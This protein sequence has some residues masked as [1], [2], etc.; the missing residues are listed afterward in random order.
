MRKTIKDH[1]FLAGTETC[2]SKRD[3][4]CGLRRTRRD[5][6]RF[7]LSTNQA[8]DSDLLV[9]KL[10]LLKVLTRRI[11]FA[12]EPAAQTLVVYRFGLELDAQEFTRKLGEILDFVNLGE[13]TI[14]SKASRFG[15]RPSYRAILQTYV[16][17]DNRPAVVQV[18]I[19][20]SSLC[21]SV[22]RKLFVR[23]VV[24]AR[25]FHPIIFKLQ[26][27]VLRQGL[28]GVLSKPLSREQT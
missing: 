25:H 10:H 13:P 14:E 22:S 20:R 12:V 6:E 16:F 8:S 27:V 28:Q 2:R 3:Q 26:F 7:A 21:V 17:E 18:N 24:N 9:L 5:F 23:A 19:S 4:Q 15:S 1:G 11:S